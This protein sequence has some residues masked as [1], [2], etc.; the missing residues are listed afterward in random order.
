MLVLGTSA[1]PIQTN[2]DYS[3][4]FAWTRGRRI[5]D[6][7]VLRTRIE[8]RVP[9]YFQPKFGLECGRVDSASRFTFSLDPPASGTHATLHPNRSLP[10]RHNTTLTPMH[11]SFVIV[12]VGGFGSCSSEANLVVGVLACTCPRVNMSTSSSIDS[13]PSHQQSRPG[14]V[15]PFARSDLRPIGHLRN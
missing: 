9:I 6:L 3:N 11:A 1:R 2:R 14:L 12:V 8:T 13:D 7:T 5:P 15:R 4:W 10:L